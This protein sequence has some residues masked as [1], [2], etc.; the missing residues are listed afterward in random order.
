MELSMQ[1]IKYEHIL[2][3]SLI[4]KEYT[5]QMA[6]HNQDVMKQGFVSYNTN[7]L[8]QFMDN[9]KANIPDKIRITIYGIDNQ[10]VSILQYDG[11]LIIFTI[12]YFDDKSTYQTNYGYKIIKRFRR[13]NKEYLTDYFL[14][15]LYND[16][17][18]LFIEP[19]ITKQT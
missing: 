10:N 1:D 16:Y 13:K 2:E 19:V 18:P 15:T 3:L 5:F 8:Q 14:V 9:V 7:R 11:S 17:I 4:P 6:L 12:R